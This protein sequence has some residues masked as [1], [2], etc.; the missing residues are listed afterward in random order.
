MCKYHKVN[1]SNCSYSPRSGKSPAGS[2]TLS[3]LHP[4]SVPPSRSSPK[5][6]RCNRRPACRPGR[7]RQPYSG[8]G[9]GQL[10]RARAEV[11]FITNAWKFPV[12]FKKDAEKTMILSSEITHTWHF[13]ENVHIIYNMLLTYTA[14]F[15]HTITFI[16]LKKMWLY[17]PCRFE[18]IL[19]RYLTIY[20]FLFVLSKYVRFFAF[21]PQPVLCRSLLKISTY[22]NLFACYRDYVYIL[23][24]H[25]ILSCFS[26]IFQHI[27]HLQ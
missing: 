27:W 18:S 21:F 15:L 1:K 11:T 24:P 14:Y 17:I 2:C 22:Y 25:D 3:S 23:F 6:H 19:C 16:F 7:I 13:S 9:W 5:Y 8:P 10:E 12:G 26:C 20:F 4:Q